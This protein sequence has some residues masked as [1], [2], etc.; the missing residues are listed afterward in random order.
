WSRRTVRQTS[1]QSME[2]QSGVRSGGA[3]AGIS[4]A[5]ISACL[6]GSVGRGS[7]VTEHPRDVSPLS[8]RGGLA[9]G[10]LTLDPIDY[11]SALACSLIPPPLPH[12]RSLQFAF[13]EGETT[14]LLRSSSGSTPGIEVVPVGRWCIIRD[15]GCVSPQCLTTYRFGPN[16]SASLAG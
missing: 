6:P 2:C 14:G 1:F 16:L 13:P 7:L 3:P 8:R 11:R 15:G 10:G 4:A 9:R 12:Q 5:V